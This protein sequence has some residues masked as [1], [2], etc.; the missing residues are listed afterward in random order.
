MLEDKSSCYFGETGK[1]M[2]CRSKEH[3]SKFNSK[4]QATRE[5]SAFYKHMETKH[6]GI[7]PNQTFGDLFDIK[8]LKAYKKPFTRNA[9]EG[10]YIANHNGELLNSKS[11]WHQPRIVRTKITIVQGGADQHLEAGVGGQGRRPGRPTGGGRS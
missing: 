9:E 6:G 11:E 1:N 2:H 3:V 8:V 7:Q 4:V 10:T 5:E